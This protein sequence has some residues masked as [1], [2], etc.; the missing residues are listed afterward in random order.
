M[1]TVTAQLGPGMQTTISARQ[2][3]FTADEPPAG[4]GTD[5]GP[6]PYEILLGSLA[7]C[8]AITL[9]WYADR[10]GLPLHGVDVTLSYDRVH[11]DDCEEC[12]DEARGLIE[13]VRSETTIRGDFTE[14]QRARLAQIAERCPV[15]KTLTRGVQIFDRVSFEDPA[16]VN[17]P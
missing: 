9:R 10:K 3:T 12:D 13:R 7:A 8:T 17:A 6:T 16:R 1:A 15:H 11:A 4:G 2:F 5:Q 14:A